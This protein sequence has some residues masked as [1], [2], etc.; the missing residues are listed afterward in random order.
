[1]LLKSTMCTLLLYPNNTIATGITLMKTYRTKSRF[2]CK[3]IISYRLYY[4]HK[5]TMDNAFLDECAYSVYINI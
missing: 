5:V 3:N 1:V 2:A 4:I